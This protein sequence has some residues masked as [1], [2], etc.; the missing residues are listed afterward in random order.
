MQQLRRPFQGVGNIIR[1]N[2]HF[3]L[4]AFLCTSLLL[5]GYFIVNDYFKFYL[6]ILVIIVSLSTTVSLV[7]S[8]F[9]YDY[10]DLYSLKWL[11]KSSEDI[12]IVNINAGFDETTLLL[13]QVY[14]QS[15]IQ[16]L[17]FYDEKKHTEI[18]I[19]RA[20]RAYPQ[21]Q[22]CLPITT[23]DIPVPFQ[24]IDQIFLILAA[25]EIRNPIERTLFF[26]EL[27]RILKPDGVVYVVEHLRDI[28]NFL[29]FNIGFLHFYNRKTWLKNFN[30][31]D[32]KV[33]KEKKH[34]PF[35]SIFKLMKNDCTP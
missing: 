34:T 22:S 32:F 6:S 30:N 24:S 19:K 8:F 7:A 25:H 23:N 26:K 12:K 14:P 20:R 2:W 17:D 27:N 5:L 35:I 1:F 4:I 21:A 3:Y 15:T 31:S 29:A 11:H 18:S 33:V 28:P 10:S 13:K 16:I 9:I